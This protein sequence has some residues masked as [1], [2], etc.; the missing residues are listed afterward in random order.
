MSQ[1]VIFVV[2]AI[3]FAITVY[4]AVMAGGLAMTWI[5]IEQ[6]PDRK[7]NVDDDELKKRFPL[8]M[9]Y[10][11][12]A[13]TDAAP[14]PSCSPSPDCRVAVSITVEPVIAHPPAW[15]RRV[16]LRQRW[17]ELAYFHWRFEPEVVQRQLPAGVTVDTFDGAAWVGLIPFEMRNV[18]L[19]TTPPLPWLG[20]FLEINVR[21]YVVDALGRRAVWFFSLDVPRSVIVA[22]ARSVFALPYCWAKASH[23]RDGHRH[24]YEMT[25]CW[26]RRPGAFAQIG[27][28]VGDAIQDDEVSDLDHFL[29]A[30]WALVTQRRKQLLSGQVRHS[31]WPLQ[32][33]T[34]VA[35]DE[36]VIEAAGLPAPTGSPHALFS[37]GVDVEVAWFQNVP[38]QEAR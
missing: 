7:K 4:G 11:K 22:V 2:G 18:Q 13:T 23:E 19:G 24:R 33:V 16:V 9:K 3:V 5:E 21:T 36:T 31:R 32:R 8:R 38:A 26:P 6:N 17:A 34:D 27:F 15:N 29:S 37:P 30:R 12:C 25:R 28:T 1:T 10:E 14:K 35:I 20:S